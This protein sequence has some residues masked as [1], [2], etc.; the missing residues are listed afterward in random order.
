MTQGSQGSQALDPKRLRRWLR[1]ME[2]RVSKLPSLKE[3]M[4]LNADDLKKFSVESAVSINFYSSSS[5]KY[6]SMI[7]LFEISITHK[8]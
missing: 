5:S 1:E 8:L 7:A 3:A 4:K 2:S 6:R